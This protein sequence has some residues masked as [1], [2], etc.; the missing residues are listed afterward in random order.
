MLVSSRGGCGDKEARG[1]VVCK[2]V[3]LYIDPR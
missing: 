1:L 2:N 3:S